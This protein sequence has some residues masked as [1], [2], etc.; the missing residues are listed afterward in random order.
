MN[1]WT[2]Q[3][4]PTSEKLSTQDTGCGMPGTLDDWDGLKERERERVREWGKSVL[5]VRLDD[6][7]DD[8]DCWN[9]T[10]LLTTSFQVISYFHG[11]IFIF[12]KTNERFYLLLV[13]WDC[14]KKRF[15]YFYD[16]KFKL[17]HFETFWHYIF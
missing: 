4:W 10:F 13:L 3:C 16:L 7:D 2:W 8:N 14:V 15:D 17:K 11:Y 6:N 1:S 9:W 12:F 5:A